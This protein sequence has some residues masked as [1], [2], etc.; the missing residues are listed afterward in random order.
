MSSTSHPAWL[1]QVQQFRSNDPSLEATKGGDVARDDPIAVGAS[2]GAIADGLEAEA[3][4]PGDQADACDEVVIGG[5]VYVRAG[6]FRQLA[7]G[8][9]LPVF[10]AQGHPDAVERG[11]SAGSYDPD[12]AER[13]RLVCTKLGLAK[14]IPE[15]N[16]E[17]M[18][19][20]FVVF[21]MLRAAI[22]R[23]LLPSAGAQ[24]GVSLAS[25]QVAPA[26]E[27]PVYRFLK[28]GERIQATDEY[29][30]DDHITW[31]PV[32]EG[33]FKGAQYGA[34]M[35]PVRRA[36]AVN[37]NRIP[38]AFLFICQEELVRTRITSLPQKY[39]I[40]K[41]RG[42]TQD[43]LAA[44]M[45]STAKAFEAAVKAAGGVV[46]G[47]PGEPAQSQTSYPAAQPGGMPP[48]MVVM[49]DKAFA[50]RRPD[51]A[52]Y[53]RIETVDGVD[54]RDL[55]GA[56]TP[57]DGRRIAREQGFEPTHWTG[58]NACGFHAF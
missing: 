21:G 32:G 51:K 22:E 48:V 34:L 50:A 8:R 49:E 35:K 23:K 37:A 53:L 30:D 33:L 44:W 47:Q 31:L 46:P 10:I 56:V 1:D 15:S 14:A 28:R 16:A 36:V 4:R 55:P 29:V 27:E 54:M 41:E 9:N 39:E 20:Q 2:R 26:D 58:P 52:F 5:K 11:E 38:E 7:D 24:L 6:G 19:A 40:A 43:E 12:A 42:M 17:L 3:A 13:L 45:R 57:L 18:E 25:E